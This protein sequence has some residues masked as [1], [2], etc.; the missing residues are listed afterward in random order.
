MAYTPFCQDAGHIVQLLVSLIDQV[1]GADDVGGRSLFPLSDGIAIAS[2][3]ASFGHSRA[4]WR[5]VDVLRS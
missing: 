5:V 4:S 2:F 3:L 1:L